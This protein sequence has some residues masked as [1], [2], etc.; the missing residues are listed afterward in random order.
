MINLP[1]ELIIMIYKYDITYYNIYNKCILQL[2][3]KK[4]FKN[5]LNNINKIKFMPIYSIPKIFNKKV[6]FYWI[7]NYINN[8]I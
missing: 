7:K 6:N 8:C 1:N 4:N 2:K 3:I 5:I